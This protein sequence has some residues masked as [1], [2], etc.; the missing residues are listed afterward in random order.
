MLRETERKQEAILKDIEALEEEL[1]KLIDISSLP[2]GRKGVLVWPAQGLL[3]QGYGETPFTKSARG[4]HFYRFHNGID[5]AAETGTPVAAADEGVVVAVG[6]T[7]VYCPRGAYGKYIVIQ[8]PRNLAT[9][10]AHL[11]FIKVAKNKKVN[12]GEVIG[13]AGSSG[14]STGPHLH[15]T[16][17]DARTVEI[18][19]GKIGT[20]GPLP[21]GGSVDPMKYL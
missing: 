10:Y 6:N 4:R 16:V 13:Y 18:K 5:I 1:R 8:H 2:V 11:S 20:C 21:F 14:L 9:M 19:L 15:F 3:T 17:Y 7:D 12:R